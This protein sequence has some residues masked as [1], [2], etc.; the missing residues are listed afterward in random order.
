MK[1]KIALFT[2]VSLP[3]IASDQPSSPLNCT[4]RV[5]FLFHEVHATI[6]EALEENSELLE[7][8]NWRDRTRNALIDDQC[9]QVLKY[10]AQE[11][12]RYADLVALHAISGHP[13][14]TALQTI[15]DKWD[16]IWRTEFSPEELAVIQSFQ[17]ILSDG[18]QA[19]Q[20][21]TATLLTT[22][23]AQYPTEFHADSSLQIPVVKI[24]TPATTRRDS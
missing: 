24:E 13:E 7:R 2:L 4:Q 18:N 6:S 22:L 9:S 11:P 10:V 19:G 17:S 21:H 15:M 20:N 5:A 3:L 1:L 14:A 8:N 16:K 12:K 23:Q